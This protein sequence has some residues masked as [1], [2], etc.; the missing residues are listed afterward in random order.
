MENKYNDY[1]DKENIIEDIAMCDILCK[2]LSLSFTSY[3]IYEM[4]YD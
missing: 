3:L 2:A 1:D 4:S